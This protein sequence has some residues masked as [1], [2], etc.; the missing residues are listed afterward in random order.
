M[1]KGYVHA[2]INNNKD[3][4]YDFDGNLL[5]PE[6]DLHFDEE[7]QIAYSDRGGILYDADLNVLA[8]GYKEFKCISEGIVWA[9][10]Q[11][12]KW[13]ALDCKTGKTIIPHI[14]ADCYSFKGGVCEVRLKRNGKSIW[15]DKSGNEVAAPAND[16][17]SSLTIN[18][19]TRLKNGL[20]QD[21]FGNI[22]SKEIKPVRKPVLYFDMDGV[23]V[24]FKSALKKQT[25]ETLAEYEG[26]EDDIPGLFG[27]MDPMPGAIEAVHKLTE[28]Y[29]CDILSTA[30]WAN[31]SSWADKVRWV[32]DHL[33]D[34]FHKKV[35]LTHH[36]NML[37]DGKAYLI[38]DRTKHGA[39]EFGKRHIHFGS[40]KFP[41]WQSVLDYLEKEN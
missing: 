11:Q 26:H 9:K 31:P 32:T 34:V 39:E 18:Y 28:K 7:E 5:S 24:D 37:N 33:D 16:E 21:Y 41:D 6:Y 20:Y 12:N 30:P 22:Q 10:D 29:D 27:Q 23:L 38:D 4:I 17:K 2:W 8:K 40:Q 3:D 14:Y 36:K 15:I 1:G 25:P 19:I 35:I 13:G